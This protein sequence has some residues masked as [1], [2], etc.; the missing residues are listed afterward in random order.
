MITLCGFAV[1]NYY[2]VAKVTP[3]REKLKPRGVRLLTL[4]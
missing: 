3:A 4:Y 1:S 2:N